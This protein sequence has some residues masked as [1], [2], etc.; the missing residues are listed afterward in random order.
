MPTEARASAPPSGQR[1]LLELRV[2]RVLDEELGRADEA[3]AAYR[4]LLERDPT[5]VQAAGALER[6]L[7]RLDRR[8]DLLGDHAVGASRQGQGFG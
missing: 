7:R 4:A 8:D 1:R 2:A 3:I 6:I 5:D